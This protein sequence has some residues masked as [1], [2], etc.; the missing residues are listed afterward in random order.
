MAAL[1]LPRSA[2]AKPLPRLAHR[3]K[4]RYRDEILPLLGVFE[5]DQGP[6]H[7]RKWYNIA[8]G[9]VHSGHIQI[10]KTRFQPVQEFL[11]R[12]RQIAEIT[13]PYTRSYQFF[14][15]S[16]FVPLYRLYF[17]SMHWVTGIATGP[18]GKP[19]Y[20]ITDDLHRQNYYIDATHARILPDKEFTPLSIHVPPDEK[21]IVVDIKKQ[22]MTALEGDRIVFQTGVATGVETDLNELEPGDIPTDTPTGAF[23]IRRKMPLR[24][25]GEGNLVSSLEA[26]ELPGVPWVG[27]FVSTGVAFHGTYWHDNYGRKMS[28]GCV[29]MRPEEAQWLYRWTTPY[30][31]P[32]QWYVQG[33]GTLVQVYE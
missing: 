9:F 31:G 23:R 29:N 10:V 11:P 7:N 12:K 18:E 22:T 26:Y 28:H 30:A 25:M 8:G 21:R 15:N 16:N 3:I 19:F 2:C 14:R 4:Y 5:S 33:E 17:K 1:P 20:E 24:H 32:E 27:F 13:V 6:A